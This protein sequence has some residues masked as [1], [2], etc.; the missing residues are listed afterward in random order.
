ADGEIQVIALY[1]RDQL[2]DPDAVC[3]EPLLA[4]AHA[5]FAYFAAA[6]VDSRDL[7]HLPEPRLDVVVGEVAKVPARPL[8]NETV[9]EDGLGVCVKLLDDRLLRL[10]GKRG[11]DS[12][13]L[14]ANVG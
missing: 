5:Y 1:Q 9:I 4:H 11:P 3:I 7:R 10:Q 8:P 2:L 13:D 6:D 12:A 14:L